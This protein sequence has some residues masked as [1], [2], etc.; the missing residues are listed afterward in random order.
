MNKHILSKFTITVLTVGALSLPMQAAEQTKK[1]E[2]GS[3]S[4]PAMAT[5]AASA[6]PSAAAASEAGATKALP[7]HGKI[8][9][10]D[11]AAKTFTLE[12][13]KGEARTFMVTDALKPTKGEKEPP[14][15]DALVVGAEV[16]GTYKKNA[17]GKLEVVSLK[18][19]GKESGETKPA[20]SEKPAK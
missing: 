7:F 12:S 5:P 4:K 18:V 13:K 14:A 19:G 10:V 8:A 3:A 9:S 6:A 20:K 2:K 11:K 17:D 15:W 1:P 16:S